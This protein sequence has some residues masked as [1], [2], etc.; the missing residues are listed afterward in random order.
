MARARDVCSECSGRGWFYCDAGPSGDT[1]TCSYC[2]GAGDWDDLGL[3]ER[4]PVRSP[5]LMGGATFDGEL[6]SPAVADELRGLGRMA[7]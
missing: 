7:A 3:I 2:D 6:V 4:A 1:E 5:V